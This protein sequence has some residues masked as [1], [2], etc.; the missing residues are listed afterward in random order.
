MHYNKTLVGPRTYS[1]LK[2]CKLPLNEISL[3]LLLAFIEMPIDTTK[4]EALRRIKYIC[5]LYLIN[6][7][8]QKDVLYIFDYLL[9][10][11]SL[12]HNQIFLW[13]F[14]TLEPIRHENKD[15]LQQWKVDVLELLQHLKNDY[16]DVCLMVL[17][18]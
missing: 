8:I 17:S 14:L 2:R 11:F 6:S 10:L 7:T 5:D 18:K 15:D 12:P 1:Q 4:I 16:F 9:V 3:V 13:N